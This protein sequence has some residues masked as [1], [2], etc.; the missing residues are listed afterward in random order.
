[1][2]L[3]GTWLPHICSW[4]QMFRHF[5]RFLGFAS[6]IEFNQLFLTWAHRSMS[7]SQRGARQKQSH[8]GAYLSIFESSLELRH[9][10]TNC[11]SYRP[12]IPLNWEQFSRGHRRVFLCHLFHMRGSSESGTC[13]FFDK[14]CH[15]LAFPC[16]LSPYP[17]ISNQEVV[18]LNALL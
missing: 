7:R 3:L 16:S 5:R 14:T 4:V 17:V 12:G 13:F 18:C 9:Y 15:M 11:I 10:L 8:L 6:C 1:M 2:H